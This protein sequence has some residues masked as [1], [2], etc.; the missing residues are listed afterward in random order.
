MTESPAWA[1]DLPSADDWKR[2]GIDQSWSRLIDVP[3][4]DTA[5]HRWHVLDTGKIRET[6]ALGTVLCIHGNPTWSFLWRKVISR[7]VDRPLRLVAPDLIGFGLSE[8]P[9]HLTAHSPE[10]HVEWIGALARALDLRDLLV[11]WQGWGGP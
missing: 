6:P 1:P 9:R 7:L 5:S 10:A 11:A 3:S 4:Y 2:W 8:K